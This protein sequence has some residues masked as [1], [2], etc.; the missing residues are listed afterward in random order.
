MHYILI[1]SWATTVQRSSQQG[2][3]AMFTAPVI[4]ALFVFAAVAAATALDRV[5]A[6]ADAKTSLDLRMSY[7]IAAFKAADHARKLDIAADAIK[8]VWHGVP[9][10]LPLPSAAALAV[11]LPAPSPL[12]RD[13]R[14]NWRNR[15]TGRFV[16]S[17]VK[18]AAA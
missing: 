11:T 9:A 3:Q 14:G 18:V 7:R 13:A 12:Y 4:F 8:P 16:A 2:N 17:P 1:P 5:W 10:G 15:T 6:H